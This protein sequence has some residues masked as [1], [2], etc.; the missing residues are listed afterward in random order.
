VE[1]R[2]ACDG[3]QSVGPGWT[4]AF[5]AD[6][7]DEEFKSEHIQPAGNPSQARSAADNLE[8]A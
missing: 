7:I 8:A 4:Q 3:V 5:E 2:A 6:P 1:T